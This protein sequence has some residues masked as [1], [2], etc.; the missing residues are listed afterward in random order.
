MAG[1][2]R[3]AAMSPARARLVSVDGVNGAAVQTA[4]REA[5]AEAARGRRGGVSSWDASGL[6]E[7]LAVGDTEVEAGTP[8]ART[9]LLLFAA[10]LMFRLRW[11]IQPS[12]AEGRVVVAAPYVDSAVAFGRAWGITNAWL[13]NLFS[14]APRPVER[15][16]VDAAPAR[17]R[18]DRVGFVEFCCERLPG[19]PLALTR[20]QLLDR[21]RAHLRTRALRR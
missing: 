1:A 12:L 17:A 9:L 5:L 15:R 2:E 16:Y 14:F 11:E 19:P 8:S 20:Q 7:E 18:S 13:T 21:V 3:T 4:A 10:D 6:F